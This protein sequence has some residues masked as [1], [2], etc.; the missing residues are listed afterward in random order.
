MTAQPQAATIG[1]VLQAL[2]GAPYLTRLGELANGSRLGRRRIHPP[3]MLFAY[4]AL[5]RHFRSANHTDAELASGLWPRLRTAATEAG[6]DDPGAKPYAFEHYT[7]QRDRLIK[8]DERR[9]LLLTEFTA[10][11]VSH[12]RRL[13]LL[14]PNGPGSL[15]HPHPTRTIY[16][17][18]T[19]VRPLYRPPRPHDY[20]I[21]PDTGK[22][23]PR[24][25]NTTTGELSTTPTVRHD[26]SAADHGRHDGIVNG[27]D[28]VLFSTR[29]EYPGTRV[30]LGIERVPR[31]NQEAD[32]A[33]QLIQRIHQQAVGGIQAVVYDGAFQGTHI[34]RIMRSTGLI[35]VNKLAAATRTPD[36][37]ATPKRR[38]LGTHTHTT[39]GR[40]CT[41]TLHLVNGTVVD[42][43]LADDGTPVD[44][45]TATRKQVKRA[46][47]KDGTY[48][49]NLA[50]TLPCGKD[51]I[52]LW[53]SP[54]DNPEHIRLIPPDDPHFPTLYSLRND[55]ESLN[56]QY[57]KTLLVDR[58]TSVGWQRQLFDVL[59]YSI[60]HNSITWQG[61]GIRRERPAA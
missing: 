24:Y 54:H 26:P 31:P 11:A 7:Y 51:E 44:I 21:D 22:E 58:A 2:F 16:G 41:H 39:K 45:A 9:E 27:N 14:K 38:P 23:I 33:V 57:K 43:A 52:L 8:D 6:L 12:A 53:L 15:T 49:Y 60:L 35:V 40:D 1:N 36:G 13:G 25:L 18:G 28:F 59:A 34:D 29:D 3:W 20:I 17:D 55:A 30:I 50:V 56:A 61:S 10:I 5:A 48:R 32:T 46:T 19:I 47:R 37:Q 42:V 4:G